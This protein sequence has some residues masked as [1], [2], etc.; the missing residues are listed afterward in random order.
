[1]A[2]SRI[3]LSPTPGL[4]CGAIPEPSSVTSNSSSSVT[5]KITLHVLAD[6]WRTTLVTA[7]SATR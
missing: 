1:M 3:E 7:S 5:L 4:E 2:R 6:A